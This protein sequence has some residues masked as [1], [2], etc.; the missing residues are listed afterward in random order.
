MV[1]AEFICN[2]LGYPGWCKLVLSWDEGSYL[3][4]EVY[5]I[6]YSMSS[7]C[8][9][10]QTPSCCPCNLNKRIQICDNVYSSLHDWMI[11]LL[12]HLY[13]SHLD[14]ERKLAVAIISVENQ[15]SFSCCRL[16]AVT[17]AGYILSG[18]VLVSLRFDV[19]QMWDH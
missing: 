19:S 3:L 17:F 8:I 4:S 10:E 1:A 15:K 13:K 12:N 16:F 5:H 7:C 2:N 18:D 11:T 9:T 6:A 14:K